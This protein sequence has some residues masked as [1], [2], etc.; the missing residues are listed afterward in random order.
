MYRERFFAPNGRTW[1]GPGEGLVP[2]GLETIPSDP[3]SWALMFAEGESDAL[4]LREAFAGT[5]EAHEL[6][7]VCVLGLPGASSWRP[8]WSSIAAT[9]DRVYVIG[10]G[11]EAGRKMIAKVNADVRWARPVRLPGRRGRPLDSP[12]G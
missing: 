12:A 1:W 10:D 2:F 5:T 7:R 8:E 11:D 9:F 4:A 6:G 3:D